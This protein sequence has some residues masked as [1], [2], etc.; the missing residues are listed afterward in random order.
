MRREGEGRESWVGLRS[1]LELQ[2][3]F[4]G[5]VASGE[6]KQCRVGLGMYWS[7]AGCFLYCCIVG[8]I[9]FG[10]GILNWVCW[11]AEKR[12]ERP[13]TWSFKWSNK[14]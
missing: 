6:E 1:L 14:E 8:R 12:Q 13:R 3:N 5:L 7:T 4:L 11:A 2:F 9:G 10:L